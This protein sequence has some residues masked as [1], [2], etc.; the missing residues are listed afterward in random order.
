MRKRRG[1][2]EGVGRSGRTTKKVKTYL[3]ELR[4][5]KPQKSYQVIATR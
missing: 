2:G 4:R 5:G 1:K 3:G